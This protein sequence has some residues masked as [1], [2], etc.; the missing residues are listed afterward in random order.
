MQ[1]DI[2]GEGSAR[3]MKS[4]M[5]QGKKPGVTS[6]LT[7]TS[8]QNFTLITS[9]R[10]KQAETAGRRYKGERSNSSSGAIPSR[11]KTWRSNL[12]VTVAE[13]GMGMLSDLLLSGSR[14]AIVD[15]ARFSD[16]CIW[17]AIG[18]IRV[19]VRIRIGD[20]R[21]P[22]INAETTNRTEILD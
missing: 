4:E 5:N 19:R 7:I 17:R 11:S 6:K 10:D 9:S 18:G 8:R 22:G 12:P 16:G 15:S 2:C 1:L 13:R 20:A 21:N 3:E 14:I